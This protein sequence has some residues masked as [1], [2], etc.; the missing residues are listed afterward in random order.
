MNN[1]EKMGHSLRVR[2]ERWEKIEKKAWELSLKEKRPI[3]PTD[4]AD[5][6]LYKYTDKITIDDVKAAKEDR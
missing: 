6:I 5:A 3:K 2:D 1:E 4:I